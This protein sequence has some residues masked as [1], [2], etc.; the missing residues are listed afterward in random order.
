M[1]VKDWTWQFIRVGQ[2]RELMGKCRE[3]QASDTGVQC[4][5]GM[6]EARQVKLPARKS[7]YT[8]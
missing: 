7:A 4:C 3:S 5:M 2:S 6:P 8:S 1:K